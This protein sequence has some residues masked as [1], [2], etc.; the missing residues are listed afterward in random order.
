MQ[1]TV[2]CVV[3]AHKR[4]YRTMSRTNYPTN[5]GTPQ[6][7]EYEYDDETPPSIAVVRAIAILEDTDPMDFPSD[8]EVR[9]H[10]YI[11]PEALNSIFSNE[12]EDTNPEMSFNI[13]STEETYIVQITDE[14]IVTAM[15]AR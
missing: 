2:T 15:Y 1:D 10:D 3:L 12:T 7:V 8:I 5:E 4:W 6:E 13:G 11:D 14:G 9:L